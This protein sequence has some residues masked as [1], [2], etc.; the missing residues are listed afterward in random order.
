MCGILAIDSMYVAT[1]PCSSLLGMEAASTTRDEPTMTLN[2]SNGD[3][4]KLKVI[5]I[6]GR[7]LGLEDEEHGADIPDS[8]H[9]WVVTSSLNLNLSYYIG[10]ELIQVGERIFWQQSYKCPSSNL[11]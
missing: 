11:M 4:S 1:E 7:A 9:W 8:N 6:F 2:L 3:D 10:A 5:E